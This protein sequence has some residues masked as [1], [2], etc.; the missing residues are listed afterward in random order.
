MY[1]FWFI[2]ILSICLLVMYLFFRMVMRE[3]GGGIR[4]RGRTLV[5]KDNDD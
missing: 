3:G 5:D 2:P 1:L 4:S